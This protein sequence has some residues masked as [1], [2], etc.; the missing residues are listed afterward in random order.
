MA[1]VGLGLRCSEKF[2]KPGLVAQARERTGA[3]HVDEH[4]PVARLTQNG[5]DPLRLG[6]QGLEV[7]TREDTVE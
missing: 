2:F 6:P 1:G 4:V 3:N 5:G 7:A